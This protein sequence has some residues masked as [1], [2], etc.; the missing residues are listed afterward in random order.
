MKCLF[1]IVVARYSLALTLLLNRYRSWTDRSRWRTLRPMSQADASCLKK[2]VLALSRTVDASRHTLGRLA[3]RRLEVPEE[4]PFELRFNGTAYA[5]MMVS[6]ADLEDFVVG[7]SLT[8]A[9][10]DDPLAIKGIDIAGDG[11]G[12]V[13]D[14]VLHGANYAALLRDNSRIIPGRSGCG[15]CGVRTL[16]DA[17]RELPHCPPS[18]SI[19]FEAIRAALSAVDR[20]HQA[21]GT[22]AAACCTVDGALGAMREDVGRH[23]ALDKLIG[24]L[25]RGTKRPDLT[26]GFCLITSR[27]SYE[28]V[29]KAVRGGFSTLVAIGTPTALA[30]CIAEEA[31]L[32][33][34]A[35]ARQDDC[36]RFD[37]GA[38]AKQEIVL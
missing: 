34:V 37:A 4:T 32:S 38:K 2:E 19:G 3:P 23:N 20:V 24:G 13:A 7:F 28:M 10:I 25:N 35:L 31:G 6:P 33:V 8:E 14:V 18:T 5:T 22:H 27:C 30:L 12:L 11:G 29:Q 9:I 36:Y 16:E 26:D 17:Q 1:P 21:K 15:M